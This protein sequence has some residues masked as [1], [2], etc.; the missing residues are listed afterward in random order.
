M[1]PEAPLT[2]TEIVAVFGLLADL[3]KQAGENR[4]VHGG[5]A[6]G[7][8]GGL[9]FFSQLPLFV[10]A[11]L[12]AILCIR[13]L[14]FSPLIASKLAPTLLSAVTWRQLQITGNQHQLT[15]RIAPFAQA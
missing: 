15:M 5:V 12:L 14:A 11:S 6:F 1:H 3:A 2:R 4:L 8:L 10:G 13:R 9:V 7:A